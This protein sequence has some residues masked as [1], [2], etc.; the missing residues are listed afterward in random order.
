MQGQIAPIYLPTY[1]L[2]LILKCPYSTAQSENPGEAM[3]VL[4]RVGMCFV[5]PECHHTFI[6]KLRKRLRQSKTRHFISH[7][8]Y[9][10]FFF[11]FDDFF[12]SQKP[13]VKLL[14]SQSF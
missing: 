12:K 9:V 5:D 13:S 14:Y 4:I 10:C 8:F 3:F 11:F 1:Y 2:I 6:W 7:V